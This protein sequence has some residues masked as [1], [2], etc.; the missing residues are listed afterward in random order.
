[1]RTHQQTSD[2]SQQVCEALQAGSSEDARELLIMV[3][4]TVLQLKETL[5]TE[6]HFY[7]STSTDECDGRACT[8]LDKQEVE[9]HSQQEDSSSVEDFLLPFS[10]GS[11]E[12]GLEC[13]GDANNV[14]IDG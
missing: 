3:V 8:S 5:L 4:I 2:R 1:M 13:W 10:G 7:V 14:L 6:R 9:A 12:R 11:E